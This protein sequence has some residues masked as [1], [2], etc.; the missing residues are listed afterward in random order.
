M[1]RNAYQKKIDKRIERLY[2]AR[3]SGIQIGIMDIG[4]V[5]KA[6]YD[7]IAA[8]EN[9]TDVALG[10]TIAAYVETIRHN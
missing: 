5:F 8:N 3:C 1:A 9:I 7:A 2:Y 4:K 10:D 6:G